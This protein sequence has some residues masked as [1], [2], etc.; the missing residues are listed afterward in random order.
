M[1]A[2]ISLSPDPLNDQETEMGIRCAAMNRVTQTG[3]PD[4]YVRSRG[5]HDGR[6]RA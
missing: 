5:P 6:V 2:R 1:R 3:M 4:S